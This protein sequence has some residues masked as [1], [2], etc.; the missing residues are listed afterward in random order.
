MKLQVLDIKTIEFN[1]TLYNPTAYQIGQP[2]WVD[3]VKPH[4]AEIGVEVSVGSLD[5]IDK[6]KNWFISV[7]IQMWNWHDNTVDIISGFSPEIQYEL[8]HGNAY[9]ILNHE[10]ESFTN[11]FFDILYS[12]LKNSKLPPNKIIYMVGAADADREYQIYVKK[13]DLPKNQQIRIMKSFHVYK[14]FEYEL[15]DFECDPNAKKEKK[16]LSLNRVG[17]LHRVM[18]IGLL[19]YYD[20]IDQGFVSLGLTKFE[21]VKVL[22]ELRNRIPVIHHGV[23][24]GISKIIDRLP[25]K[26]DNVDLKVNQFGTNSLPRS[27]YEKSYFSLVSSTF[28]LKIDECSVGFTEKEIKPILHKHPFIIY[29]LPGALKSLR[30]MGFLTFGKWFDESYDDEVDD[31]KRLSMIVLEIKRLS[32][33][34][35]DIWNAWLIEMKPILLHNY[36][37][38]VKYTTE[39]SFFNSDLKDFL[40]YVAS[41]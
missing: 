32:E 23:V 30:A 3:F 25:L 10:C 11:I 9:L 4:L 12:F 26:V 16:F 22:Q 29:N 28:A 5:Q 35:D 17:K 19:S 18:L 34:S 33:I 20:L 40:Y 15:I 31:I 8:I 14:R 13:Y 41:V 36:N 6:L 37:R 24:P 2:F 39:H 21:M 7:A 1:K 38:L 27:F